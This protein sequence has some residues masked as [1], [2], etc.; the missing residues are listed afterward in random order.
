M[1]V[2]TD[3]QATNMV[4]L[5]WRSDVFKDLGEP[6]VPSYLD[7]HKIL[8]NHTPHVPI[9]IEPKD[10]TIIQIIERQWY[11]NLVRSTLNFLLLCPHMSSR[12]ASMPSTPPRQYMHLVVLTNWPQR[13]LVI[14]VLWTHHLS[15]YLHQFP[16]LIFKLLHI[17][18][19]SVSH[20]NTLQCNQSWRSAWFETILA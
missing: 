2:H 9:V 13:V 14:H 19:P 17:T 3:K 12:W 10:S 4:L 16:H 7:T 6:Y 5:T 11:E 18:H 8:Q 15:V 20:F 1:I